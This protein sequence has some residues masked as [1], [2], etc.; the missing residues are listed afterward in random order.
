MKL[1]ER[2]EQV[3]ARR[4][5][6]RS[7]RECYWNWIVEFLRFHRSDGAWR[8]PAELNQTHVEAFLNDLAV[9]KRVSASTQNQALCALVFL[10]KHV[11][12]DEVGEKHLGRF[13]FERARR[14]RRVPTVLGPDETARLLATMQIGSVQRLLVELLYGAGLRV[15]ECC[16]LRL[17]DIDFAR[18]Q[19]IVRGGK[20]DK[21][22]LVMLPE[23]V[24]RPLVQHVARV[25]EQ[26]DEDLQRDGGWV[27][28][29]ISLGHKRPSAAREVQMQYLF[30]SRLIRR[31]A[32]G[33]GFRWHMTP[34]HAD[35]IV[36]RAAHAAGIA[37]RVTCHTLRHSFATHLLEQGWDIRQVQQLLGHVK[38]ETTMIYTHVM[39]KPSIAV[40]SPL[41]QLAVAG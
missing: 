14:P 21:D 8:P 2:F 41:D 31:D 33:K 3:A 19:I 30:G 34:S 20:G 32:S 35:E 40:R 22:R 26:Y 29:P 25:R 7:T 15:M 39:N 27:E 11:V 18:K 13:E 12:V 37:K 4:R 16:T 1:V 28:I 38:L 9:R 17:R 24:V 10:Y 36:V 6:A 5:L 23:S